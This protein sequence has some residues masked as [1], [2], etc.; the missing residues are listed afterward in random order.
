MHIVLK[1]DRPSQIRFGSTLKLDGSWTAVEPD[2]P[3]V[4]PLTWWTG[5]RLEPEFF[6]PK[7]AT[8]L[9]LNLGSEPLH[10]VSHCISH[11]HSQQYHAISMWNLKTGRIK[12]NMGIRPRNIKL[13]KSCRLLCY[14]WLVQI[15]LHQLDK[16]DSSQKFNNNKNANNLK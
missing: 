7:W 13:K 1:M 4:G 12:C 14:L 2:D 15:F 9:G 5:C 10:E 11:N 3:A 8:L 16:I 6:G